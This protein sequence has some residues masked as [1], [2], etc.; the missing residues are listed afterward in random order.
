MSGNGAGSMGRI[1]R[2]QQVRDQQSWEWGPFVNYGNGVGNRDQYKFFWAG[3]AVRQAAYA[4]DSRRHLPAGSFSWRATSC[5][6]GWRTRRL[7]TIRRLHLPGPSGVV[8]CVL[9]TGGGTFSGVSLTPVILRWNFLTQL[10]ALAAVV[11]RGGRAGLHHA[12]VSAEYS[13]IPHGNRRVAPSCGISPRRAGAA[14]II[15]C[16]RND[17]S[18][19]A[20]MRCIFRRHRWA[21]ITPA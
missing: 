18:I 7:R 14:Y 20:S 16:A 9:P 2:W 12:Q 10:E 19:W 5:P 11:S 8:P 1:I 13:G 21:T 6:C 3:A 4:G 15:L 17:R